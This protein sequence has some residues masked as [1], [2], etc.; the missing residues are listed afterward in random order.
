VQTPLNEVCNKSSQVKDCGHETVFEINI[1]VFIGWWWK[2]IQ[3]E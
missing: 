2:T 3:K 1:T